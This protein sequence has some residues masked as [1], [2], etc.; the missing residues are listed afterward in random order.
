MDAELLFDDRFVLSDRAFAQ[1]KVWCVPAS[2]RGSSHRLKYS[3]AFVV[4][5]EC[6]LRYDNEAGKGD[7]RH[8]DGIETPLEFDDLNG[9]LVDFWK[10]VGKWIAQ[11]GS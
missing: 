8:M 4:D 2:V 6:V 3:F 7:H 11:N 10:E 1:V 5:S 9:L